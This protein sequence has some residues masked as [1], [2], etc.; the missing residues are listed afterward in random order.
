[1]V[2]IYCK[3]VVVGIFGGLDFILVFLV[4]VKIF[5]KLDLLWKG[6][7]G[8]I[9]FGFGIIDCIYNN[10]FYLMVL[11]GVIIK[12]ISIKEFCI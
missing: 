1:M 6:I 9:M 5:D 11:L 2:Y 12:E 4:C 10:V 8:I 3:I 7:I